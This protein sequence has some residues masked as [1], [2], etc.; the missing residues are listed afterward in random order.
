LRFGYAICYTRDTRLLDIDGHKNPKPIHQPKDNFL[1]TKTAMILAFIYGMIFLTPIAEA[2]SPIETGVIA[3]APLSV[4]P[5]T[6]EAREG[7]ANVSVFK[8]GNIDWLPE[9][10]LAAGWKPAQF[11]KLGHIILR[12]SGGC[13][14]RIGSSIVDK[15]CNI[16]GYTKA[17]NK[18]D[19]GLLQINGVNWD[20]SRNKNAI[21]CVKFG[22]CTQEPLLDP[23][24]NL[25]VGRA[26]F[27]VAGWEPW[28]VCNWNPKA[29]GC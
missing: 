12:E 15:N 22:F 13:P 2:K 28:N 8:H 18:S 27:E 5:E 16:T 14:N 20:L 11:K 1:I 26:L 23:L 3:L 10:A 9:L 6:R 4:L 19:S 21:A 7:T 24:N 25:K 17:T 29:K